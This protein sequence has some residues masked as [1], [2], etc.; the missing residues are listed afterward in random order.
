MTG[1]TE[2]KTRCC[3]EVSLLSKA[4]LNNATHTEYQQPLPRKYSRVCD[5]CKV[6]NTWQAI[7]GSAAYSRLGCPGYRVDLACIQQLMHARTL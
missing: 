1:F 4:C 2:T 3:H 5:V 6:Y 7:P